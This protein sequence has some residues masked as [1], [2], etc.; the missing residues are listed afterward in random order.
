MAGRAQCSQCGKDFSQRLDKC[1]SC[2]PASVKRSDADLQMEVEAK[3]ARWRMLPSAPMRDAVSWPEA[4]EMLWC[5]GG[6]GGVFVLRLPT[7]VVCLK[8]ESCTLGMLFA[9]KLA[10]SLSVRTAWMRAV[11]NHLP[12]HKAIC[13][14][15]EHALP[16][17]DDHRFQTSRVKSA[18]TVVVMEFIAG[19][20]MMG[21]PGNTYLR[22]HRETA[23]FW[24]A[25]GRLMG[26]DLLINNF[27]RLPLAWSNEG[28]LGNVMLSTDLDGPVGI[29]QSTQPITD[30][31]GLRNY[32]DRVRKVC[33]EARD[34]EGASFKAV[35]QAI[36][37][38]TA[39]TLS[40]EELEHLRQ[41]CF[42]FLKEVAQLTTA[43]EMDR[44]LDKTSDNVRSELG[45]SPV[46][47]C[48]L[49]RKVASV[50]QETLGEDCIA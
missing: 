28:N 29:D 18:E 27:D 44:M 30:A 22:Q 8:T 39:I 31:V 47:Q 36:Y 20:A 49:I 24:Q 48:D 4:T 50:L 7:G 32:L 6:S 40:S 21:M 13:S 2:F 5:H 37:I 23:H 25:L 41:G 43:G 35:K 3:H 12:E 45:S 15:L 38:N 10:D 9:Q 33:I 14:A 16:T 26:F 34:G 19:C 42:E 46:K 1:P 11:P 17:F